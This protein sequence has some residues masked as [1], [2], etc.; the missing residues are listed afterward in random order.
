MFTV[1]RTVAVTVTRAG[2]AAR[3][4]VALTTATH[5][6]SFLFATFSLLCMSLFLLLF[7]WSSS[8]FLFT[9]LLLFLVGRRITAL[10]IGTGR[11]RR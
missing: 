1:I 5:H 8:L 7:R 2:T 9:S 10:R 11:R 3:T 4:A 6:L